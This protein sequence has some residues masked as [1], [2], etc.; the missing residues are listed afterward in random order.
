MQ[1]HACGPYIGTCTC[2][3]MHVHVAAVSVMLVCDDV[4]WCTVVA[5]G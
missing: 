1:I 4:M 5:G 2:M 3:C